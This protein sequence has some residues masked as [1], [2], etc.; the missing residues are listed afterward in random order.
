MHVTSGLF[1][2][3]MEVEM[4]EILLQNLFCDFRFSE[5]WLSKNLKQNEGNVF[6]CSL[7]G[8]ISGNGFQI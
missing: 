2:G 4:M 5:K 6:L 1:G 8:F 3:I 7:I